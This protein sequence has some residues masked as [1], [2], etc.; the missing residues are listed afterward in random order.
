MMSDI[1]ANRPAFEPL[2]QRSNVRGLLQLAVPK[3]ATLGAYFWYV[4]GLPFWAERLRTTLRN[5]RTTR[6]IWPLRQLAWNMPHHAE[7]HACPALPFR[8]L[9]KAHALVA[10]AITI[11]AAGYLAA[12]R[13][14]LQRL[15]KNP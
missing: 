15:L 12:H 11:Q 7:H 4:G 13:G 3:P 8:A 5:S 6:S 2:M 9:P 14:L 1:T 10:H